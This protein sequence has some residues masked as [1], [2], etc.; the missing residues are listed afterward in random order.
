MP[1]YDIPAPAIPVAGLL[2]FI[3]LTGLVGIIT[4]FR[5]PAKALPAP[6]YKAM[7]RK[8]VELISQEIKDL[9][10]AGNQ[11][12]L[13]TYQ[14][15]S[16][17]LTYEGEDRYHLCL[18]HI[19]V[20]DIAEINVIRAT[21][22]EI[23]QGRYNEHLFYTADREEGKVPVFIKVALSGAKSPD[24][25]AGHIRESISRMFEQREKFYRKEISWEMMGKNMGIDDF[26]RHLLEKGF[27]RSAISKQ[28]ARHLMPR[29]ERTSDYMHPMLLGTLLPRLCDAGL[30]PFR[31]LQV[32]TDED[33]WSTKDAYAIQTFDILSPIVE[34]D[35]DGL[36]R[37]KAPHATLLIN[38]NAA[39]DSN[40]PDELLTITLQVENRTE[41]AI[42]VRTTICRTPVPGN[43]METVS[44]DNIYMDNLSLTLA[45]TVQPDDKRVT[46]V[47]YMWHEAVD[48]RT[49]GD[50]ENL[51]EE[52]KYMLFYAQDRDVYESIYWGRKHMLEGRYY[53][54]LLYLECAYEVLAPQY[55]RMKRE[56]RERF[57]E[58]CYQIGF[59]Y[60]ELKLYKEAYVYLEAVAGKGNLAYTMEYVNCLVNSKDH[61]ALGVVNT[62]I[63]QAEQYRN[64][65][66]GDVSDNT[67]E[68]YD[69]L[70]RRKAYLLVDTDRL[71]DAEQ[72]LKSMLGEPGNS[73]FALDELAYIQNLR[74]DKDSES[75]NKS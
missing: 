16:F 4:F 8:A 39:T 28:E 74:R 53:E 58:L 54:A 30:P 40:T 51:T 61:R 3:A 11:V 57:Y 10:N 68:F 17:L 42:Y 41:T 72:L 22:N 36:A 64:D 52:E 23:N 62:L 56:G 65:T 67:Q 18:P 66:E 19:M 12:L 6:D 44:D 20:G 38:C 50:Y 29:P 27:E 14:D 69:F 33:V 15:A 43:G 1:M 32:I 37:V 31:R 46:E 48:A 21:I 5:R 71:D 70:R 60:N 34:R 75:G 2:I 35:E 47:D 9:S 25:L 7:M 49:R 73:D 26:E 59:C 13:F 24:E 63:G 55:D 45:A